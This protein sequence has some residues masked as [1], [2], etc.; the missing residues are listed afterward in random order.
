[1]SQNGAGQRGAAEIP[2]HAEKEYAGENGTANGAA[3]LP[4][5]A[6]EQEFADDGS[7]EYRENGLTVLP[8][9]TLKRVQVSIERSDY[10]F[11]N[12]LASLEWQILEKFD[13]PLSGSL[14]SDAL[15]G[16]EEGEAPAGMAAPTVFGVTSALVG[17][18][19]TTVAMHLAFSIARN[20]FK[21]VCLIDLG[22]GEDEICRRLGVKQEVGV[23]NVLDG[24]ETI[25][26]TLQV[27]DCG[28]LSIMPAGPAPENPTKTS[29]SPAVPEVI[30]A[31]RQMFDIIIVDMP[32]VLTGNALPIASYL[33]RVMLVVC[34]GVTPRDV[35]NDALDRIGR[36]RTLGV[37]LNRIKPSSPRW[38]QKRLSRI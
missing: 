11:A 38:V 12:L 3:P 36:K 21:K 4:E 37:V 24:T 28:E 26:H 32:A 5:G 6:E 2:V 17:E 23:V 29:R 35:V 19:K 1:M 7:R 34:A 22:M 27:A 9:E 31:A 25:I 16:A 8:S 10:Q 33:D 13:I 20:S 14:L 15:A 30:A 18:G